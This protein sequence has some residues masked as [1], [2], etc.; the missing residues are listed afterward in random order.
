MSK[1]TT[2]LVSSGKKLNYQQNS[3]AVTVRLSFSVVEG[4]QA[5]RKVD[6]SNE[7]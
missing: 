7:K 6:K 4:H 2:I 5:V 3:C 1:P